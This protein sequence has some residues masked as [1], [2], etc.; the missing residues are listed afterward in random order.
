MED[1]EELE[2]GLSFENI[3]VMKKSSF[4]NLVNKSIAEDAFKKLEKLKLSHSKVENVKHR[5]LQIR[6]YFLPSN[7]KA[8]KDEIQLIFKLRSRMTETK[9]NYKGLYDTYE[10]DVC[11]DEDESQAH[12]LKCS[13]LVNMNKESIEIPNYEMIFEGNVDDK[14]KD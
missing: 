7:T 11:G 9:T 1:L 6:K 5:M 2:L 14:V 3:K 10:C 12:I 13:K 8:T 4:N